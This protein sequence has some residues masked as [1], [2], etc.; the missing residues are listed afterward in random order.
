MFV[1]AD[2]EGVFFLLHGGFFHNRRLIKSLK[3]ARIA[4][5]FEMKLKGHKEK[6]T[7]FLILMK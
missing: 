4:M 7:I 5:K 6:L 2:I 1:K 3:R